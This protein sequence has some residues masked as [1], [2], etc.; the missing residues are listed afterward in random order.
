MRHLKVGDLVR[1]R[2]SS[3]QKPVGVVIERIKDERTDYFAWRVFVDG[4][5]LP[6]HQRWL[7][8]VDIVG[9]KK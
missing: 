8:P 7:E 1:V 5:V 6:Y 2:A 4:V 3:T 9:E